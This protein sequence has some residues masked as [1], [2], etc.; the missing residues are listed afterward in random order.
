ML[1]RHLRF[2]SLIATIVVGAF[3]APAAAQ[4]ESETVPPDNS[5]A[6][7]Y[8]EAFPTA[9][10]NRDAYG[11]DRRRTPREALGARK[12]RELERRGP[13]GKEVAE[14]VAET[15]PAGTSYAASGAAHGDTPATA[16]E[17]SAGRGDGPSPSG[18]RG[19]AEEQAGDGTPASGASG[20]GDGS[21]GTGAAPAAVDGSSGLVSTISAAL[22]S[23]D[24]NGTLLP[25]ALL[26]TALWAV[27]Y[28]ALRGRRR[29]AE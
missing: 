21:G 3:A 18:G 10:G 15:A 11:H 14:L 19:T 4:E 2:A 7:Q 26:L 13:A 28:G 29:T 22:G 25:V 24:G 12:A 23:T 16:P 1:S 8:T 17:A 5:A 9:G 27:L 6:T 20:D